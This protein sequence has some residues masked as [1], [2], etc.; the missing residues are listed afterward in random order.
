MTNSEKIQKAL[1]QLKVAAMELAN[2]IDETEY[3]LQNAPEF[4]EDADDFA[5]DIISFVEDEI[6]DLK[7]DK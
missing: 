7:G 5:F 4:L 1:I 3:D 2:I 6:E